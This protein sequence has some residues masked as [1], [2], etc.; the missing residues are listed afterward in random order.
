MYALR[1]S[2]SEENVV[3]M[4]RRKILKPEVALI[5]EGWL[6]PVPPEPTR[7]RKMWKKLV[8]KS[9]KIIASCADRLTEI[10]A[11]DRREIGLS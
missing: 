4:P 2:L 7:V 6:D 1:L 8:S 10:D 9:K 5:M 11:S 3:S